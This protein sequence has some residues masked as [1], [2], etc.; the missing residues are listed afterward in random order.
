MENI[1]LRQVLSV[2]DK[3][4]PFSVSTLRFDDSSEWLK[5]KSYLYIPS[6]IENDFNNALHE[7]KAGDLFFLCG[8]SGDGKSEILTR[9]YQ[10]FQAKIKFHLDATHSKKQHSTAVEC[11]NELFDDHKETNCILAIGINIG[12]MQKFIKFGAQR[13][14]DIKQY[15]KQFFLR[16]QTTPFIIDKAHFFDFEDYPRLIFSNNSITS[17]FVSAFIDKLTKESDSNPFWQAYLYDLKNS[18]F[19]ACNYKLLLNKTV[20]KNLIELLGLIRLYDN[21]FLTPR[22]FVDFIYKLIVTQNDDGLVGNLFSYLDNDI[23]QKIVEL[24]P[25]RIRNKTIDDFVLAYSTRTLSDEDNIYIDYLNQLSGTTLSLKGLIQLSYLMKDDDN[26]YL[27]KLSNAFNNKEKEYYLKLIEIY[28]ADDISLEDEAIL[29]EIITKTFI[30][31]IYK[32]VNRH[33]PESGD[34]YIITREL[35]HYFISSKADIYFDFNWIKNYKLIRT[36]SIPIPL[37]INEQ[38]PIIFNLDINLLALALKIRN[39]F[40]PNRQKQEELLQFEELI[41]Q[42]IKNIKTIED[43]QLFDRENN[44][45]T[46]IVKNRSGYSIKENVI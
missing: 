22:M 3:S 25:N 10:R 40:L 32:Y 18:D 2:L 37:I 30:G 4:S 29:D 28:S 14:E 9:L 15:L 43:I 39:G 6:E 7:A 5:I 31:A 23:S 21:Q 19:P 41:S 26:E 1:T 35:P 17:T 36:C 42:I 33:L 46:K 20:Q 11:L 38:E 16:T 44:K 8:S 45:T 12:M 34:S 13:H 27:S 24:E